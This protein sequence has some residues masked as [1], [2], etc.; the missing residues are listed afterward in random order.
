[1]SKKDKKVEEETVVEK[2]Q[3]EKVIDK[4]VPNAQTALTF[5]RDMCRDYVMCICNISKQTKHDLDTCL[6]YLQDYI[7]KDIVVGGFIQ[8]QLNKKSLDNYSKSYTNS[9]YKITLTITKEDS[10]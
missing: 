4:H 9:G 6:Q 1:M 5:V 7:R 8:E 10:K 3:E 2:K